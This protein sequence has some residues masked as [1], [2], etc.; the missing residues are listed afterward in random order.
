VPLDSPVLQAVC[1]ILPA[2]LVVAI[3]LYTRKRLDRAVA[4]GVFIALTSG[5]A[6]QKGLFL[7][8]YLFKPDSPQVATKLHGYEREIFAAGAIVV[9]L[10]LVSIWAMCEEAAKS[11]ED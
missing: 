6:I 5:F 7:C 10:A 3:S 1:A 2:L 11:S 8:S 4:G 9:F